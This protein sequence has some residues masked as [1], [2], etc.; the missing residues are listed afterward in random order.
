M[1]SGKPDMDSSH[2]IRLGEKIAFGLG[3]MNN[4][5]MNNI[6]NVLLNPIYNIALGVSPALIG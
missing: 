3:N 1:N 4:L 6:L 5:L 2:K